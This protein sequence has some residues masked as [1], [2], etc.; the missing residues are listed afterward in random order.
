LLLLLARRA[1]KLIMQ[2]AAAG[3]HAHQQGVIHRD[4]KPSN[5][6][7]IC[8]FGVA[9]LLAAGTGRP[10]RRPRRRDGAG[11]GGGNLATPACRGG[12]IASASRDKTVRLWDAKAGAELAVLPH[13]G[14]VYGVAF[15]P[16]GTRLATACRDNTIRLWDVATR[17]EVA[18][19]RGLRPRRRLQPRR[20]SAGLGL[21]RLHRPGLGHACPSGP[22]PASEQRPAGLKALKSTFPGRH[23]TNPIKSA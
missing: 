21:G 14:D 12:E 4:L 6:P 3:Q 22:R 17:K 19:L 16:D 1:A 9:K 23:A 2:L 8:D 18:E 10:D 11:P 7:K 15:S 5:I 13:A 20:H